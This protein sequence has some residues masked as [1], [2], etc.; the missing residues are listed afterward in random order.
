MSPKIS[1][2]SDSEEEEFYESLEYADEPNTVLK[3]TQLKEVSSEDPT[4]VAENSTH[5]IPKTVASVEASEINI[6]PP[7]PLTEEEIEERVQE[8]ESYKAVG[9]QL[10]G[11]GEY[12]SAVEK[13]N[14]ALE[15]CPKEKPSLLALLHGNIAACYIKLERLEDA[16]SACDSALALEPTYV[17][18]LVRR[19]QANE[20]I[21]KYLALSSAL[22]DYKKLLDIA[23]NYRR[24]C[25]RALVRL[26]PRIEEQQEIEKAEMLEKVKDL[27]NRFLGMFGLSTDNFQ[28]QKDP[29]TGNYSMQ[30]KLRNYA[31]VSKPKRPLNGKYQPAEVEKGWYEWWEKQ[32]YFS[33]THRHSRAGEQKITTV[34]TPPPNVTGNLHIG[35]ALTFSVQDSL[36]RWRRMCGEAVSWIPGTDHAGIGTQSV[37]EKQLMKQHKLTRHDLGRDKFISEVW[38]WKELH[39]NKIIEQMRKMGSSLDW[40]NEF[41]TMDAPRTEAV[42]NAF[43]QFFKDGLLYRDTRIVNWCCHLETAIS[44]IEVDYETVQGQTF[45]TLP[46]REDKV[47]VGVLHKLAY[48]V[49]DPVGDIEE[50]V[51]ATTRIETI[52][53][54]CALAIHPEDPRYK[55]LHGK[56][57][58]HPVL[59]QKIPII[60]DPELVDPDFG[61]GVVK[62]TPGHDPNDYACGRRHNLPLTSIM[63][64]TGT[65]NEL[66][67]VRKYQNKDR[68]IVRNEI[69]EDLISSGAYRG[70]DVNHEMRISRCSRSG[71]II[72]PMVQPQWFLNCQEMAKTA[73]KNMDNG[74]MNITPGHHKPDWYRWLEN[75]QDWCVSRQLWWGHRIPAYRLIFNDPEIR[76]VI[77]G[78]ASSNELWFVAESKEKAIEQVSDFLNQHKISNQT[79]YSLEQDDDVL[80]TWF[81]SALLPLSALGWDGKSKSL[82][83]Y[84]TAFIET[85]FDILFFWVARMAMLST[86][87]SGSP[88]FKDIYLHAMIRDSQGRKMSKSLGNVID[89]LHVINGI[90]LNE[91]RQALHSGNLASEEIKRS[92]SVMEKEFP[93]GI[94]ACGTD[95]LRFSLVSYTQQ[96]RQIN[97]DISNVTSA[98]HF[99][100]KLWNL[101]RF[102]FGRFDTL[103]E[104]V[105]PISDSLAVPSITKLEEQPLVNKYILSRLADTVRKTHSAM[106]E[107]QLHQATDSIRRFVVNDLCDVYLEFSKPTLYGKSTIEEQRSATLILTTCLDT[108]LRLLHPFMPFVTEELWQNLIAH[109]NPE[110]STQPESLMVTEFP[111]PEKFGAFYDEQ[112]ESE[113]QIIL[114][115]IHASRSLR[116]TQHVSISQELP[117]S[118]WTD[119]PDLLGPLRRYSSELQNFVKA[120]SLEIVHGQEAEIPS[121]VAVSTISPNLKVFVPVSALKS[122]GSNSKVQGEIDRIKRKMAKITKEIEDLEDKINKPEYEVRVPE[123]VKLSNSK[124]LAMFKEQLTSFQTNLGLLE[125]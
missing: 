79:D 98:L 12:E 40:K 17:K 29:S 90:S 104:Y 13:Y 3:E 109:T 106:S 16:V 36:V 32:G 82:E 99:G 88:P 66:C 112:V 86:Y 49:V 47:E 70:K 43:I 85:G 122:V 44:D 37:V 25:E 30:F 18:A 52:L 72:E 87:F 123:R 124:R 116:Q 22:E 58:L 89:P 1:E 9:N 33:P 97:M 75:I 62:V 41:F 78:S 108:S 5:A 39:G 46:G 76:K 11:S 50:L 7:T 10:F 26:P 114:S 14:Q 28:M 64:K 84:P 15:I 121:D 45:L 77:Q 115:L 27:G 34:L 96:T 100:N 56:F 113:M 107:Y 71:D 38:K 92:E 111:A 24:E 102:S 103:R 67:G 68:Y 54:D 53:G 2:I 61:T 69:V 105:P 73:I 63:D 20:K 21:G 65:F 51:V 120:T 35:H 74:S 60:C 31:Q 8:V 48:K 125:K 119:Q 83:N 59:N 81:S 94:P 95:A 6:I 42:T 80:D 110:S 55:T 93:D 101:C 4:V 23:P 118:V 57:V 19:A 117:F 91:L